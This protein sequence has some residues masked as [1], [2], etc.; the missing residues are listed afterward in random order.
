MITDR[1]SLNLAYLYLRQFE[2]TIG[3]ITDIEMVKIPLAS[4]TSK[5]LTRFANLADA[6]TFIQANTPLIPFDKLDCSPLS[7]YEIKAI[8][9]ET[10]NSNKNFIYSEDKVFK[11]KSTNVNQAGLDILNKSYMPNYIKVL[12]Q[13]NEIKFNEYI[14]L[15][16]TYI[17]CGY[18]NTFFIEDYQELLAL[19]KKYKN[20]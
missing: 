18:I 9:V 3:K 15:Q 6:L 5:G 7:L 8:N 2:N 4:N 11:T 20:R 17:D 14:E 19:Y 12:N 1:I 13:F 10:D 16:Y